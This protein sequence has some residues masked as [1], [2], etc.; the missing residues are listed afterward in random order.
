[1]TTMHAIAAPSYGSLDQLKV[2]TLPLPEP[3]SQEVRVRVHASALNAADYKVVTGTLKFL[4]ARNFPLVVGY[5]FSG[6]IDAVGPGESSWKA[7]DEV[8]GFLPYSPGNR[9]GA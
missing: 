1:M 8:F 9:R 5:D 2:I 4:H 7:G 6:T 3:R